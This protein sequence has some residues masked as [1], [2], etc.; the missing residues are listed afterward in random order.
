MSKPNPVV[1]KF[2]TKASKWRK[3][4]MLLRA[5]ARGC[6][7]DEDFK[8]GW[9]CYTLE[10]KNIVLLHGFKDYCAVLFFKGAL[11]KNEAGLLVQQTK[12]V[13]SARQVRYTAEEGI[14]QSKTQLKRLIM[15]AIAVERSGRKV[16]FKEAEDFD[17]PLEFADA[18]AKSR[19]LKAA[20]EAL[21]PGRRRGYLLH[22][23]GAKQSKTRADRII[24]CSERILAGKGLSD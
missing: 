19:K 5:I 21:T 14:K 3:E 7:L 15:E 10:G 13:Q 18:L 9:P 11:V 23:S 12:N 22:F 4:F 16:D 2:L 20:F 17:L 6:G 8:W 1:E 24:K